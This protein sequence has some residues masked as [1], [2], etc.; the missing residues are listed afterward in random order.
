MSETSTTVGDEATFEAE[1]AAAA[2]ANDCEDLEDVLD[3]LAGLRARIA[4]AAATPQ[5]LLA[6]VERLERKVDT[7]LR[8]P[9]RLLSKRAAARLLGVDRGTSLEALLRAGRL[10]LVRG[11]VPLAALERLLA[12]G[13]PAT[14]GR[15]RRRRREL[16]RPADEAAAIRRLKL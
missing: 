2:A 6:A 13:V 9:P 11:K 7:A 8:G 15:A 16:G 14:G 4:A 10:R 1:K 12:E 5:S 3:H